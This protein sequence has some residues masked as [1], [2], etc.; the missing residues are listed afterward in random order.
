MKDPTKIRE[1]RTGAALAPELT[2]EMLEAVEELSPPA[3]VGGLP[4][5]P[6][7][8]AYVLNAEPAGTM[9]P[10]AGL[11]E[12]AESVLNAIQGKNPLVL[13][14]ALGA[15]LAF[16]RTGTRIYEALLTKARSLDVV[17]GG[18]SVADLEAIHQDELDHF[19]ILK[20]AIESLGGDPTVMTPTANVYAVASIGPLQVVSDPRMGMRESMH[21]ILTIE[22]TD[23]DGWDLLIRLANA[24]NQTD[25]VETFSAC[26]LAEA[27]HL[28]RVREWLTAMTEVAATGDLVSDADLTPAS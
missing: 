3:Q 7:R 12:M 5:E 10:A 28:T 4:L 25:M 8:A 24:F 13:L 16:E 14:D 17:E 1:N 26:S 23:N 2:A 22:L 6:I 21:A 9:P 20:D 11:K 18:P 27:E 19:R 15:R